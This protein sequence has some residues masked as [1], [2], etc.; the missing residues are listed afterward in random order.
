MEIHK[1][2]TLCSVLNHFRLLWIKD[3][4]ADKTLPLKFAILCCNE[5]SRA[6]TLGFKDKMVIFK[7]DSD[8]KPIL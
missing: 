7:T 5:L 1:Q 4:K 6:D 8:D 3:G 2:T